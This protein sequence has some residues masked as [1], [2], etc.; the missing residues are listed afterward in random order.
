MPFQT[1]VLSTD[2]LVYLLVAVIVATIVYVRG[3]EHLRAPWRRVAQS[4]SGMVGLTVL[5][6]FVVVGLL[7]SLHFRP[8]LG[9]GGRQWPRSLMRSKC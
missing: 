6:V 9:G 8:R 3:S 5:L 1:V 4:T 2:W 7:D